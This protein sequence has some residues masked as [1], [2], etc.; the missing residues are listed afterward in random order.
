MQRSWVSNIL[1]LDIECVPNV[2][3]YYDLD[4]WMQKCWAKKASYML[5]NAEE[6]ITEEE[7][8]ENR[9]GIYAEFG[10]II[11]I[12]VW[13]VFVEDG[14]RQFRVKS[15][16]WD[17]ETKLLSE[18]FELLNN[19]YTKPY[20]RLC[21]HN[22]KEF[23]IPYICRRALVNWL[24]LPDIIDTS[25]KKPWEVNHLDT[26]ELWKFGDRKNFTSLD[27]LCRI[28]GIETPKDDI[29]GEQV[30]RVYWDDKDLA[31]IQTYCEK[32][33]IATARLYLRMKWRSTDMPDDVVVSWNISL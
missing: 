10:K 22:I 12:S 33:V 28:L 19:H 1:F 15:F 18:F 20:H 21:W 3:S 24:A 26:L 7:L 17:D 25:G 16:S 9:S 23:D 4:E 5:K 2:S 29:S 32:D 31:R 27:L 11:V 6:W 8:Y 30:A 13:Y 14:H